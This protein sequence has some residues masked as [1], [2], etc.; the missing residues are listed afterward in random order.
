MFKLAVTAS[1]TAGL[2]LVVCVIAAA[3]WPKDSYFGDADPT[4]NLFWISV[5]SALIGI[6][7]FAV[8]L[9]MHAAAVTEGMRDVLRAERMEAARV[10]KAA[11]KRA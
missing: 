3:T 1:I 7:V 9:I 5:G 10:A 2:G 8:L 6:A 4:A 11:N